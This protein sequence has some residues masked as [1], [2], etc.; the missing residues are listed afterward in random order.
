LQA[1]WGGLKDEGWQGKRQA[2][3][4]IPLGGEPDDGARLYSNWLLSCRRVKLASKPPP[5]ASDPAC[6]KRTGKPPGSS[7]RWNERDREM[8]EGKRRE[9]VG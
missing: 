5:V 3:L 6:E 9:R 4:G 7:M 8:V 1:R 2:P